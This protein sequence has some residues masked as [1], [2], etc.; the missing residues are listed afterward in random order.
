MKDFYAALRRAAAPATATPVQRRN[1]IN[2]Q[3]D[4]VGI[5]LSTA[6]AT[7]LPV[8]LTLLGA[9]NFQVGLLTAMPSLTGLA[10][11][12]VVGRFLQ[13]QRQI[14]PAFSRARFLVVSAYALTG[15]M[16]FVAPPAYA[17]PA[18][19]GIWALVT[20]PQVAVNVGFSV[21]MNAVAGP[22][23]RYDLLSRRWSI[24]G[25]TSAA[26]VAVAGQVLDLIAF[27]TNYQL[28]FLALSV[29]GLISLIFSSRIVIPDQPALPPAPAGQSWLARV[30][31]ELRTIAQ[32]P[33]YVRFTAKRFVFLSG[34]ALGTPLVPLY[35]VREAHA[36]N[37]W[38][39][40]ISTTQ[41][42][43]MIFGYAFWSRASRAR[44]A[45]FALT[46]TT[47]GLALYPALLSTTQ[48][49]RV[50][51]GL[52]GLAG[53]FQAGLDLVFFDELMKTVPP[54]R[55]AVFV[56][57]A[58]SLQYLSGVA[59]PLLGTVLA[60]NLGLGGALLVSAALRGL[61]WALFTLAGRPAAK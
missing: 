25:L 16:P 7:F 11:G 45:R 17:V 32:Y 6:A 57:L 36:P 31:G 23:L 5:G 33:D 52:A 50:I 40:L 28:T 19:L 59:A 26:V 18:V 42:F 21:V 48:E 30:R 24:L 22:K 56:S 46:W 41:S 61:G 27:P 4:A 9:S 12:V 47:F 51:A 14:V 10:L 35:L 60:D 13:G 1:F 49:V 20:L 43:V 54:E 34:I 44:G 39:G 37:S 8:F 3:V 58:Q 15:L 55:T 2:V 38:I 29:G 53:L